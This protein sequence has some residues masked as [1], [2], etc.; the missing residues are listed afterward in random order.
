M[1][2]H[3]FNKHYHDLKP[4][5]IDR[6]NKL[7]EEDMNQIDARFDIFSSKLQN[8]YN[9]SKS[10]VE[11][12]FHNWKPNVRFEVENEYK[13][14]KIQF[15]KEQ[16]INIR[17]NLV[18]AGVTFALLIGIFGVTQNYTTTDGEFIAD[19]SY[20]NLI[21]M[22]K[23]ISKTN[24]DEILTENIRQALF[25]N[26][27]L[28]AVLQGFKIENSDGVVTVQGTVKNEDEKN[29]VKEQIEMIPGVV[30][31]INNIEIRN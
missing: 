13:S 12:Q 31:V 19:G 24:P 21:A 8:K 15:A 11:E 7:T 20:E 9:I 30:K 18:G 29:L 22:A 6:W 14:K 17:K 26:P 2:R 28:L 25:S 23:P 10:H 27:F 4:Y 5:I 1:E 16:E 3:Q